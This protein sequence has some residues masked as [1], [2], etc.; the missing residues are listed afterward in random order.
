MAGFEDLIRSTLKKQG[1]IH[2]DRRAAIYESSRQALERMILQNDKLSGAA[3]RVQ[4]ERLEAAITSIEE[5]YSRAEHLH[6]SE[7]P[8]PMVDPSPPVS[9][10]FPSGEDLHSTEP[11]PPKIDPSPPVSVE[12]PA[13]TTVSKSSDPPWRNPEPEVDYSGKQTGAAG[14]P[15]QPKLKPEPAPT[16]E[17]TPA[18]APL[19]ASRDSAPSAVPKKGPK[20]EPTMSASAEPSS[21]RDSAPTAPPADYQGKAL[22]EKRPFAKLLLWV[23]ILAGL[24][25]GIWWAIN[26][27]PDLLKSKLSGAVDNPKPRI[28]TGS[29]VPEGEEGWVSIF[30]PDANPEGIETGDTGRAELINVDGRQVARLASGSG[31]NATIKVRVPRGVMETLRGKAAT[32]EVTLAAEAGQAQ[33][34]ALYCEFGE[35]GSCGRKRFRAKAEPEAHI[36]DVLINDTALEEGKDAFIAINTDIGAEGK[37]LDLYSIRVRTGA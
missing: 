8:P 24:G 3:A 9:D 28:E 17:A 30:S 20:V 29:F 34:F 23:I 6:D 26:F 10:T 31:E 5:D 33:Q 19:S 35:M 18:V 2:A 36:F 27:G 1:D 25:T 37:V 15:P 7:P 14:P 16:V 12:P 4:R 22:G 32:F 21:Q 13:A 11:P